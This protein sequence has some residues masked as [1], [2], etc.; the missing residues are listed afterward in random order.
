MQVLKRRPESSKPF[1]IGV[2]GA[3]LP[4]WRPE[5]IPIVEA[6]VE[7]IL[8]G[9]EVKPYLKGDSRVAQYW[10]NR[11]N[12]VPNITV[13]TGHCPI[14][15]EKWYNV[16]DNRWATPSQ[17]IGFIN[18]KSPLV[19]KGIVRDTTYV[20]VY[21]LGGVDTTTEIKTV[22]LGLRSEIYP[23]ENKGW[24]D[25]PTN[26]P[27]CDVKSLIDLDMLKHHLWKRHSANLL[28][29]GIHEYAN[30][31]E[32]RIQDYQ[33]GKPLMAYVQKTKEEI[34][35]SRNIGFRSRNIIIAKAIPETT[36]GFLYD[37]EPAGSC[38]SCNGTG[39][40]WSDKESFPCGYCEGDGAYSGGYWTYKK[41]RK[42]GKE[43]YK[44]VIK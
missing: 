12:G 26:C 18:F 9:E 37:I 1:K 5:Q 29:E 31:M 42:L 19:I 44:I 10:I 30:M 40:W 17:E 20:R 16:T 33:Y 3:S 36:R 25:E 7:G 27:L 23:A 6:V 24:G 28:Q 14:G 34:K 41:A 35:F 13:T 2:V 8:K 4:K 38:R 15:E 11:D 22:K 39:Y 43:V 21:N 32:I